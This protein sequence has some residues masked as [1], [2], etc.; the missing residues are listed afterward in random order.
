[1]QNLFTTAQIERLRREAKKLRNATPSL[2][3]SKAQDLVAAKYGYRNWSLLVKH[4]LLPVDVLNTFS[5]NKKPYPDGDMGVY[6]VHIRVTDRKLRS[7]VSNESPHFDLPNEE[8]WIFRAA[9]HPQYK[10]LPFIDERFDPQRAV[11]VN[12]EWKAILSTNGISDAEMQM[13]VGNTL[14]RILNELRMRTAM[15]LEPWLRVP[16]APRKYYLFFTCLQESGVS[17]IAE[18]SYATLDEAKNADL[19]SGCVKIRISTEDGFL[20]YQ[21]PFGWQGPWDDRRNIDGSVPSIP[22]RPKSKWFDRGFNYQVLNVPADIGGSRLYEVSRLTIS[23]DAM[24]PSDAKLIYDEIDQVSR[25]GGSD[26]TVWLD[27]QGDRIPQGVHTAVKHLVG[28]GVGLVVTINGK[29]S[30]SSSENFPDDF[31]ADLRATYRGGVLWCPVTR[32][33]M[34]P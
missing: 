5:V 28:F 18:K 19:P 16:E 21:E 13:H 22:E 20:S 32:Q 31:M 6:I 33:I 4:S 15:A 17:G 30:L 12:G 24:R 11:I 27:V 9:T 8:G 1:M 23:A 14:P 26:S 25:M 10:L 34:H 7:R 3:L 2:I 29:S